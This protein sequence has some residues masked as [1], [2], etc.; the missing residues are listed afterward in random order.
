MRL[1]WKPG[2]MFGDLCLQ[3]GLD[4]GKIPRENLIG[5][6]GEFRSYWTT[7]PCQETLAKWDHKFLQQLI[8][9]K[10]TGE[11]YANPKRNSARGAGIDWND[12]SWYDDEF[13]ARLEAIARGDEPGFLTG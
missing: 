11:L 4:P 5:I 3:S 7:R 13:H 1:D 6:L 2:P 9:K 12:A 8:R 10:S